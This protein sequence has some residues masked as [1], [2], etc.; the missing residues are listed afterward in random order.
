M[1]CV[2]REMGTRL[3]IAS[4]P[5]KALAHQLSEFGA[6]LLNFGAAFDLEEYSIE[7]TIDCLSGCF[8]VGCTCTRELAPNVAFTAQ[9][10][11]LHNSVIPGHRP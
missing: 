3:G 7:C 10:V 1:K 8:V 2:L 5:P 6:G 11:Q 4:I 9:T